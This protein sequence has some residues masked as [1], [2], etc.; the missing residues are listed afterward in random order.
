MSAVKLRRKSDKTSQLIK[1]GTPKSDSLQAQ[2]ATFFSYAAPV[3]VG[4]SKLVLSDVPLPQLLFLLATPIAVYLDKTWSKRR[5]AE[6]K[7]RRI[8]QEDF[9]NDY[10]AHIGDG[11]AIMQDIDLYSAAQARLAQSQI[12]KT[13]CALVA[14]Y[15]QESEHEKVREKF[16]ASLMLADDCAAW[17][18]PSKDK[19]KDAIRF[20]DA[21]R[22][23]QACSKILCLT[24]WAREPQNWPSFALPVDTD[25]DY[26]LPGAPRAYHTGE[27]QVIA[28]TLAVDEREKVMPK[29]AEAAKRQLRNYFEEHEKDFRSFFSLPLCSDKTTVGVLNVQSKDVDILGIDN[30]HRDDLELCLRPFCALLAALILRENSFKT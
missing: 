13:I 19:F 1:F 15:Y 18:E 17:L 25:S 3:G 7:K 26:L 12:L 6:A 14:T 5:E 21:N 4:V 24:C 16:N 10:I 8:Q 23:L 28:D 29:H 9:F 27:L 11:V 2:V 22:S 30:E 20:F